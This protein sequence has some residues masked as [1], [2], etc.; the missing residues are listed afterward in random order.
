MLHRNTP[1][2]WGPYNKKNNKQRRLIMHLCK[3]DI[4]HSAVSL[5]CLLVE[6]LRVQKA[7]KPA[8]HFTSIIFFLITDYSVQYA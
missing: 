7:Q 4:G 2:Q 3:V 6:W 1:R 5:L 8:F